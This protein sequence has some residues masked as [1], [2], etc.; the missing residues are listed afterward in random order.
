FL[1]IKK[2]NSLYLINNAQKYNKYSFK[3]AFIL[4]I[5]DEFSEK[6]AIYKIL[7]LLN[8]FSEYNQV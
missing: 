2:N 4:L 7:L 5:S 3:N 6:F 1:I 8:F